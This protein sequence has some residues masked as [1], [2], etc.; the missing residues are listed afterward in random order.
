MRIQR[1]EILPAVAALF[2]EAAKHV[3]SREFVVG[4]AMGLSMRTLFKAALVATLP[5]YYAPF[6]A[7]VVAGA[8]TG[9]LLRLRSTSKQLS[10]AEKNNNP[11]WKAEA[12]VKGAM[13]GGIGSSVGAAIGDMISGSAKYYSWFDRHGDAP[14]AMAPAPVMEVIP[15]ANAST[16]EGIPGYFQE[17]DVVKETPPAVSE[18]QVLS[19][20]EYERRLRRMRWW[21]YHH[22]DWDDHDHDYDRDDDADDKKPTKIVHVNGDESYDGKYFNPLADNQTPEHVNGN[23]SFDG[24]YYN[25]TREGNSSGHV[26]GANLTP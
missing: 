22:D 1:K 5:G 8:L 9:G 4:F 10:N 24:K 25:P 15:V 16:V 20:E 6:V 14:V 11:H 18:K 19:D 3:T 7:P 13:R 21:K 26:N 12:F 2:R 23:E 17:A